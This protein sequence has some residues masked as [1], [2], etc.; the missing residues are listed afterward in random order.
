MISFF[1]SE[2]KLEKE[3]PDAKPARTQR[4]P[5]ARPAIV[6]DTDESEEN[7]EN[8]PT[9]TVPPSPVMINSK[10][11]VCIKKTSVPSNENQV[12][13]TFWPFGKREK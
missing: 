12:K 9:T 2:H 10:K 5:S 7:D 3:L 13:C 1:P 6:L 11:P 8:E 4:R